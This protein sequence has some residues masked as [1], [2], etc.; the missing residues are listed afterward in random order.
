MASFEFDKVKAEKADALRRYKIKRS[1]TLC[2]RVT[3]ALVFL[4]WSFMSIP[5]ILGFAYS[6]VPLLRAEFCVFV[7]VN[8]IVLLVYRSSINGGHDDGFQPDLYDQYL[9]CSRSSSSS[10]SSSFYL[11]LDGTQPAALKLQVKRTVRSKSV[12]YAPLAKNM[13]RELSV[14][15]TKP[16]PEKEAKQFSR[17][18]SELSVST[19][20]RI[21]QRK[22]RP[23][24]TENERHLVVDEDYREARKSM[25]EMNSEE[26]RQTIES[27]IAKK[28]KI[29]M[30]ENHALMSEAT[31]EHKVIAHV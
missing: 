26:F 18:R 5:D 27:F 25:E 12:D 29:L 13:T 31:G 28:K 21:R 4:S 6:C 3:G 16:L 14:R 9:S 17:T 24:E 11:L 7:L 10:S 30:D 2:L 23:S 19:E 1:F 20:K 8:V 22:L 15:N